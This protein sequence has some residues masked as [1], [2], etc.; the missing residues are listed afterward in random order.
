MKEVITLGVQ[1]KSP[2]MT[3]G[4]SSQSF[5]TEWALFRSALT[6]LKEKEENQLQ[7]ELKRKISI[8]VGQ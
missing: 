1:L 4:A 3:T 2:H 5:E 6:Y 7:I 8:V